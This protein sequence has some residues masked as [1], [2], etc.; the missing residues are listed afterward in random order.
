MRWLGP[1]I[2]TM[3][4]MS[5]IFAL[6][7]ENNHHLPKQRRYP[8]WNFESKQ[9]LPGGRQIGGGGRATSDMWRLGGLLSALSRHRCASRPKSRFHYPFA[10]RIV[11]GRFGHYQPSRSIA[12]SASSG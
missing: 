1:R 2:R 4:A 12:A 9:P 10:G 3:D 11:N 8:G 6:D 5:I 7:K